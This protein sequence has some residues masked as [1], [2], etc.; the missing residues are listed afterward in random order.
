MSERASDWVSEC[1]RV[2]AICIVHSVRE[3]I[4]LCMLRVRNTNT[5]TVSTFPYVHIC[6]VDFLSLAESLFRSFAYFWFSLARFNGLVTHSLYDDNF[7]LRF[8]YNY[9]NNNIITITQLSRSLIHSHTHSAVC[10][11][12]RTR[13]N[14]AKAHK[15]PT[16]TV[17]NKLYRILR[18]CNVWL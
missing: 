18:T 10:L 16:N 6:V 12:K 7:T 8:N 4:V 15:H 9:N 11:S 5:Y 2:C 3:R 1:V 17:N 14:I 13:P